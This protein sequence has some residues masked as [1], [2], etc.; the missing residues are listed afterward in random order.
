MITF[1]HVTKKYPLGNVA[2]DDVSFT[3]DDNDFVFLVGPS[4]AGKTTILNLLM[5]EYLPTSGTIKVDGIAINSK[6]FH[7]VHELRKK[8]GIVFQDFKILPYKNIYENI[9]LSL[10]IAGRSNAETQHMV[11]NVLELVKLPHKKQ[12]FPAQL[13]AGELQRVAIARAVVGERKL[14]LADE[15]TGNLDSETGK[16]IFELL[17]N[18]ARTEKTT[19]IAVTHDLSIAGKTDVTFRL[20]DGMLKK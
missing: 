10:R 3:I 12:V 8:I 15:P 11:E 20:H 14:I 7:K 4:G 19:V 2:L 5:H 13:S 9:A 16:M 18:I 17:H 6:K 1:D